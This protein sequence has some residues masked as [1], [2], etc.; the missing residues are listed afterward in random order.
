MLEALTWHGSQWTTVMAPCHHL[1]GRPSDQIKFINNAFAEALSPNHR[2]RCASARAPYQRSPPLAD[3]Y[4]CSIYNTYSY[5][6]INYIL[7]MFSMTCL[8][9]IIIVITY[10]YTEV[11][12]ILDLKKYNI[13]MPC[14]H[15]HASA[16]NMYI[17]FT[18]NDVLCACCN[19]YN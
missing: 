1:Q 15:A 3:Y 6:P 13:S 5:V 11:T 17:H 18:E 12:F 7:C 10:I 19:N 9:I 8:L 14:M 4:A 2:P 16:P